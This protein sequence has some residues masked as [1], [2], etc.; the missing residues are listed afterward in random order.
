MQQIRLYDFGGK[1]HRQPDMVAV[2]RIVEIKHCSLYNKPGQRKQE[3]DLEYF[4]EQYG[5]LSA[6]TQIY[7][8]ETRFYI[9]DEHLQTVTDLLKKKTAQE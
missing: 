4:N 2:A 9:K 7:P 3:L 1:A 6:A 5:R 8:D